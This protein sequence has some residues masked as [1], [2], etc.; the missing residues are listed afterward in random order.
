[1]NHLRSSLPSNA[2]EFSGR[3]EQWVRVPGHK[4]NDLSLFLRTY[5]VGRSSKPVEMGLQEVVQDLVCML[6]TQHGLFNGAAFNQQ[7]SP[8]AKALLGLQ[9][10]INMN[11]FHAQ[12]K[13]A[14]LRKGQRQSMFS[15]K[16]HLQYHQF[17]K[18][19]GNKQRHAGHRG[20]LGG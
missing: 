4:P 17:R 1:M 18:R 10:G 8:L 20:R 16:E 12:L 3:M 2:K 19:A 7:P 5:V 13:S 14:N 9:R 6:G 11:H 15:C